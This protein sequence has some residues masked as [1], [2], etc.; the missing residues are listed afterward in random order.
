MGIS[1]SV[2]ISRDKVAILE[3]KSFQA[4]VIIS[5]E[6]ISRGGIAE[7]KIMHIL[8]TVEHIIK[9]LPQKSYTYPFTFLESTI[10]ER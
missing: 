8:K 7:S 2:I 1:I 9:L 5:S 4:S 10:W 3:Y 6:E